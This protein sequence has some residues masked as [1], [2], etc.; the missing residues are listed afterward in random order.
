MPAPEQLG[1]FL[2]TRVPG[3]RITYEIQC[4][5]CPT[6]GT[7]ANMQYGPMTASQ[8]L[9]RK[10]SERGWRVGKK[11]TKNRC[12]SCLVVA[13]APVCDTPTPQ[14]EPEEV[15]NAVSKPMIDITPTRADPPQ[16]ASVED[17]RIIN[18][19]L[20]D[21]YGEHGYPSGWSDERLA[22]DLGVPR[23]WVAQVREFSFGPDV[24]EDA[25]RISEAAARAVREAEK[26]VAD[27]EALCRRLTKEFEGRIAVA[28][29]VLAEAQALA[30]KVARR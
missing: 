29:G 5:S 16:Q 9:F 11:A 8:Q 23:A 13:K 18:E 20:H 10:F 2:F 24:D 19:K 22:K 4:G 25:S 27:L 3:G 12:P 28:K 6:V 7:L 14:P 30:Q 17:R 21:I 1:P 26:A 15:V